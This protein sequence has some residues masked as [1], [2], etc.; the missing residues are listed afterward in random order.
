MFVGFKFIPGGVGCLG[1]RVTA[2]LYQALLA[3]V[4]EMAILGVQRPPCSRLTGV[5]DGGNET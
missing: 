2:W 5:R 3:V 4:G 1:G